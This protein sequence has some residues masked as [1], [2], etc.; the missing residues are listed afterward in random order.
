MIEEIKK[1]VMSIYTKLYG[2]VTVDE[3]YVLDF[4]DIT[5]REI[6]IAM[7]DDWQD[8]YTKVTLDTIVITEE[9][10]YMTGLTE[11]GDSVE[12]IYFDSID[13][14]KMAS[15]ADAIWDRNYKL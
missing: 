9:D 14:D 10:I 3:S 11:N 8:C 15:I 6:A 1:N 4:T 12:E 7:E 13:T 2:E 5:K